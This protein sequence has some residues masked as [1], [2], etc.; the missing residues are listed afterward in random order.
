MALYAYEAFSRDGKKVNGL[1]DAPSIA[2][3]KESLIRQGLYP[4]SI[5]LARS[6]SRLSLWQRLFSSSV[7]MKDKILFTKQLA[8]L[9]KSGVPLLQAIELLSEQVQGLLHSIV[10]TVKD[11]IKEGASLAD[12]LNK[13]PDTFDTIYVQLVRAG[14]AS[15]KLEIILDRLTFFLE[16]RDA[17]ARKIRG[18]LQYPVIQLVI[19]LLVITVM[20]TVV[21]PQL[22]TVFAGKEE[23][24]VSTR[25]LLGVSG[26]MT[27]HYILLVCFLSITIALFLYWRSTPS[28]KLL[29]DKV[30]LKLPLIKYFVKTNVVVQFCYTLG[31]LLEGGVNLSESLDIVSKIITNQVLAQAI[32]R[33]KDN[34]VKQ[35]KIAEYLKQTNL[36]PPI[37]IHLIQTG[38]ESGQLDTMLLTVAQNYEVE[39]IE[40]SDNL[41]NLIS[42]VMT[43][44]MALI[45]GFIIISIV[46]PV[47]SAG[48]QFLQ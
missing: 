13:Y 44:V 33:A 37:A 15:G 48:Q 22:K 29:I 26:F 20:L 6:D 9:L 25:L 28:G 4:V 3:L 42:P 16:R 39:L 10:V 30:K 34:I 17:I 45:V 23:L 43:I 38:E 21:V 35:G 36:F 18:A 32:N 12:A 24:P 31:I 47:M 27:N 5:E 40:L 2:Q 8:I 19:A 11:E 14:E 7:S 46:G 41:T 1:V